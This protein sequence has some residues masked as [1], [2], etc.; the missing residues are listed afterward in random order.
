MRY[1]APSQRMGMTPR[2][3]LDGEPDTE[4]RCCSHS[5]VAAVLQPSTRSIRTYRYHPGLT[6]PD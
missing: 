2:G 6:E 3:E 5:T 1:A 4:G